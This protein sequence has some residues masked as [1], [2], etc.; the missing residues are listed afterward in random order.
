[1][2]LNDCILQR[3]QNNED[4]LYD[5]LF[6]DKEEDL[7]K[8]LMT[9]NLGGITRTHFP[10]DF[11][12]CSHYKKLLTNIL[13][14]INDDIKRGNSPT[15]YFKVIYTEHI[16]LFG[17]LN[18]VKPETQWKTLTRNFELILSDFS[19]IEESNPLVSEIFDH[20]TILESRD[21]INPN[22]L[23]FFGRLCDSVFENKGYRFSVSDGYLTTEH[24]DVVVSVFPFGK[25]KTERLSSIRKTIMG[26]PYFEDVRKVS[27]SQD[28]L[29]QVRF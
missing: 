24:R 10:F 25:K 23:L 26:L 11:I 9:F 4:S 27:K 7:L 19:S 14:T 6:T 13:R 17:M 1:M 5:K 8:V 21:L 16:F 29:D 2:E 15:D 3:I 22:F 12:H 20:L 28:I 18:L